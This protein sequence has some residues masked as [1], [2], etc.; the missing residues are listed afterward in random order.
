MEEEEQGVPSMASPPIQPVQ[1]PIQACWACNT[2]VQVPLCGEARCKATAFK[3]R[4]ALLRKVFQ[5]CC[6]AHRPSAK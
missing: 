4:N 1:P 5:A 2:N 6:Q 3:V